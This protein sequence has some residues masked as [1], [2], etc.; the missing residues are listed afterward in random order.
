VRQTVRLTRAQVLLLVGFLNAMNGFLIVYASPSA[1]TP[2]L[3][4]AIIQ[5]AGVIFSVPFSLLAL[6]DRKRYCSPA[7]ALAALLI[8]GSVGVSLAP[9]LLGSGAGAVGSGA[10]SIG[11]CLVYLLGVAASAAYN[12][13][14]QLFFVRAGMLRAGAGARAQARTMLRALFWSNAAQALT[15]VALCW[16]DLLPWFGT[17][18]SFGELLR[19]TLF[20]V[21]CSVGGPGAAAAALAAAGSVAP[22]PAAG[23]PAEDCAASTPT[24]AWAFLLSYTLSYL[25]AARLNR[26]SATFMMLTLVVV[27]MTTAAFWEIPGT[28]PNPSSTPLWSVLSSLALSVAGTLLW[29]RWEGATPA[30]EQFGVGPDADVLLREEEEAGGG[31]GAHADDRFSRALDGGGEGGSAGGWGGLW[32]S[33]GGAGEGRGGSGGGGAATGSPA[34]APRGRREDALIG[35]AYDSLLGPGEG[36]LVDVVTSG[37]SEIASIVNKFQM[38]RARNFLAGGGGARDNSP[39][40]M[41]PPSRVRGGIN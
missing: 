2:P 31:G 28:N 40:L 12:V 38:Q 27:T 33:R 13:C 6:G 1:R 14:Q 15:Y 20:S 19:A 16:V 10:S 7:P 22:P 34:G 17:T 3:V 36:P 25:G 9:A 4:Q 18:S 26:E 39:K 30:D 29:K 32:G 23:A 35:L 5:N 21:S 11:W 41:S 24:W 8:A 37:R